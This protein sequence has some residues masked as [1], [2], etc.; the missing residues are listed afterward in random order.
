L[1]EAGLYRGPVALRRLP[2]KG[3]GV[4]VT[5]DVGA[6]QL[7]LTDPCHLLSA[8]DCRKLEGMSLHGHYFAHPRNKGEGC[9]VFG[10][11]S[12]IN[13]SAIPNCHLKWIDLL[14]IGWIVKLYTRQALP[15][16]EELTIDYDC[17]LWFDAAPEDAV[18]R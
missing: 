10:P 4:I 16:G 11:I 17:P 15:A 9:L 6:D 13:H 14:E 12:L 3:R 5:T 8:N 2:G 7:L 18:R 1:E